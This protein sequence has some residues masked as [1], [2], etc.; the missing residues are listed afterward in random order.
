MDSSSA[1]GKGFAHSDMPHLLV[2][3]DN[4]SVR[5]Y[6]VELLGSNGYRVDYAEDGEAGWQRAQAH[7]YDLIITDHD[8]PRLTGVGLIQR[9]NE[10][11]SKVPIILVSGT[12]APDDERLSK[13]DF[14]C[15]VPKPF[16]CE[17]LL[18]TIKEALLVE[19]P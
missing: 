8:M 13:L 9:L 18:Q 4:S 15:L 5:H 19:F 2:V 14:F 10:S 7:K 3:E 1:A 12:L 17:S 16:S 11:E 6:Y